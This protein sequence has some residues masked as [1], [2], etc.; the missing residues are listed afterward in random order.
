[1]AASSWGRRRGDVVALDAADGD[2][3]WRASVGGTVLASPA[4]TAA[5]G[6][7]VLTDNGLVVQLDAGGGIEWSYPTGAPAVAAPTTTAD[8]VTYAPG[9]DG[10]LRAVDAGGSL[11]WSLPIGGVQNAGLATAAVQSDGWLFVGRNDGFLVAL[12]PSLTNGGPP[13]VGNSLRQ[14]RDGDDVVFS[15]Q[16]VSGIPEACAYRVRSSVERERSPAD[17]QVVDVPPD[18][19][20]HVGAVPAAP[21]LL[22]YRVHAMTCCGVEGP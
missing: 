21:A 7:V 8:G 2:E 3:L 19:S 18:P 13:G 16:S 12:K 1:M 14:V 11:L 20:R 22:Y 5:G 9:L 10:T 17:P 15:W 6:V 4:L